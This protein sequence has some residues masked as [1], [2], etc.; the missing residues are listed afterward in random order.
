[1]AY[2]KVMNSATHEIRTTV[3]GESKLV[4]TVTVRYSSYNDVTF[5]TVRGGRLTL[6]GS[7]EGRGVPETYRGRLGAQDVGRYTPGELKSYFKGRGRVV[8][9]VLKALAA[10]RI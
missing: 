7:C 2:H 9:A 5:V 8:G 3:N 6:Q 4:A 10:G 1:M